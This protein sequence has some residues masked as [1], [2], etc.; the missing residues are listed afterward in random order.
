MTTR[1]ARWSLLVLTI[2]LLA[3]WLPWAKDLLFE[4]RFGKTDLFY[5]PV[6]E[7]FV[8]K[9]LLGEGHQFVYRDEAGT[10]Y[11]REEF[12]ALIPFIYYKNM[13]LW[14]RLPLEL[15]G[16]RFDKAAI[17]AERQV[18]QLAPDE[19]PGNRPRIQLFPL[20]ESNPGRAR[21]RFPE[22]VMRPADQLIFID[23]DANRLNP[24][25]T[26]TFSAAML[27]AGFQ[28]PVR[29]TFGR[30]SIL[31]PFD[32]GYFL[33]DDN[34]R[35]F[36]LKRMDGQ[37]MVAPV[38]LPEGIAM[39]HVK[40]AENKRGE[41]LGLLL[42]RDGR[43]FLLGQRDYDLTPLPLPGYDPDT[44]A[45]K[46]IFNPLLRTAIYS[47]QTRV[48]A[49]A[50]DRDFQP[51]D[52]HSRDMAMAATRPVD[53]VWRA[54]VP[55]DIA[56]HDPNG[57]YLVLHLRPPGASAVIGILLALLPAFGLLCRRGLRGPGLLPSLLLV[58]VTGVYGLLALM[59]FPPERAR[60]AVPPAS[61]A[62]ARPVGLTAGGG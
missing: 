58:A 47:D 6:L 30:V 37:P 45:L 48:H 39:R 8:Y 22:D 31:K 7:A 27:D 3:V 46:V 15:G 44:M 42:A 25:L 23:S 49:V 51:L 52:A 26:R 5:S 1:I 38:P 10:D 16:Q 13:E 28:F 32:A 60:G 41:F 11:A 59:L 17:Q 40:V 43:L 20:L 54:L 21:L 9:E 55:F 33:L 36:H 62:N 14:G 35:L 12:E 29:A 61:A 18:L 57:R 24:E 19:L 4:Y 56:L 53:T 50:M 2:V 34:G